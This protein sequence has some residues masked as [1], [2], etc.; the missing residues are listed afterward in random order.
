MYKK[1]MDSALNDAYSFF[2][3]VSS[4]HRYVKAIARIR[5]ESP[6]PHTMTGPCLTIEILVITQRYKFDALQE[7]SEILTPE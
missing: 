1:F 4:E 6:K 7:V 3:G 2:N 5:R